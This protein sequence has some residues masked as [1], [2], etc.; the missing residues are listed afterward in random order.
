MGMKVML[1]GL[2]IIGAVAML[3]ADVSA[4]PF[5]IGNYSCAF[6]HGALKEKEQREEFIENHK[7]MRVWIIGETD[8]EQ[9]A[10]RREEVRRSLIE[11]GLPPEDIGEL[12]YKDPAL[13]PFMREGG[14]AIVTQPKYK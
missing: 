3:E 4:H 13:L 2:L 6:G 10:R 8:D 9:L 5:P 11:S 7:N 1:I 12:I 14:M